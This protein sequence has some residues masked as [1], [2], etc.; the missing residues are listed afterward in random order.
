M[1]DTIIVCT[2]LN[3]VKIQLVQSGKINLSWTL[4]F[5]DKTWNWTILGILL[6]IFFT[7]FGVNAIN[8]FGDNSGT[9]FVCVFALTSIRWM[10]C[11]FYVFNSLYSN[12][13]WNILQTSKFPR[14]IPHWWFLE[15]EKNKNCSF[16]LVKNKFKKKTL[17]F[18]RVI[19]VQ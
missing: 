5:Y 6:C 7:K 10:S 4:H 18:L 14:I 13:P 11:P 12:K 8:S 19:E 16:F 9:A 3:L 1:P 15:R 17:P 2:I